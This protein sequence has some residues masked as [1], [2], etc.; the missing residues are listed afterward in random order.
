MSEKEG[1]HGLGIFGWLFLLL[2]AFMALYFF[3]E[4]PF[5]FY[6]FAESIFTDPSEK[7]TP[8]MIQY[9]DYYRS[10][11]I[12]FLRAFFDGMVSNLISI[13]MILGFIIIVLASFLFN[14]LFI[15]IIAAYIFPYLYLNSKLHRFLSNSKNFTA[16][17]S[18]IIIISLLLALSIYLGILYHEAFIYKNHILLRLT[19]LYLPLF[20]FL[21]LEF[22]LRNTTFAKKSKAGNDQLHKIFDRTDR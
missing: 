10:D 12:S 19:Y 20:T 15:L 2:I 21:V 8:L 3:W 9:H 1:K 4:T 16:K 7:S 5:W 11:D 18:I 17:L 6:S 22:F 14:F 13:S